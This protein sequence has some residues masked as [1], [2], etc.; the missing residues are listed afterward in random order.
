MKMQRLVLAAV[1]LLAG[2]GGGGAGSAMTPSTPV[3]LQSPPAPATNAQFSIAIPAASVSSAARVRPQYMS[4][5]TRSVTI[6]VKG[7]AN[8]GTFDVSSG[9]K[10]CTG[11]SD[12]SRTCMLAV[13][14][15]SGND[16]F[17]VT[18]YDQPGGGGNALASGSIEQSIS[19]SQSTI[20]VSLTGIT[21]AIRLALQNGLPASG[22]PA[23]IP[24]IVQAIDADGNTI[25]GT[26]DR[27]I[28][29]A[30]NDS[31]RHTHLSATSIT[32]SDTAVTLSY[33]GGT[34]TGDAGITASAPGVQAPPP[35]TLHA[36]PSIVAQYDLP[37]ILSQDG[38]YRT[39]VGTSGIVQGS[40]GNLWIAGAT[41]G[42][43]LKM[44]P[45]GSITT[46]WPPTP[47]AF[48]QEEVLGKDGAV[49]FTERDGN[50]IGR[51]TTSGAITEY[52]IPT[53]Y[54]NP[55]GIA[56]GPDGN[57]WFV[58]QSGNAV[59]KVN[60]DGSI[61]EYPLPQGAVPVDLTAGPDGNLWIDE[62]GWNQPAAIAVMKTDG[63]LLTTHPL[64]KNNPMPYGIITGPDGNLWFGEYS[65]GAI[66]RM[67]PSGQVTE[68]APPSSIPGVVSLA[69][70]KDGNIWFAESGAGVA[71]TGQLGYIT[72]GSS[73]IHE[74][75]LNMPLH[76]RN[77]TFDSS[78]ALW[79]SGFY[80]DD[81]NVG[82]VIP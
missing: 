29:L 25:L 27:T 26:Y 74:V 57:I 36:M 39:A 82:E 58:E 31:S 60:A 69:V 15:P 21:S 22:K 77:I 2:C 65:G 55:L 66:A 73:T 71:A 13:Q 70:S 68:Y 5:A 78:G 48:P 46:Y 30:D 41:A 6:A 10:L 28:T 62:T 50:N 76:V 64:A 61:T 53:Q 42:A 45:D 38:T 35:V 47:Y 18:A 32:A 12:G 23:S 49:W 14:A 4:A 24:V 51:I 81:S 1:A 16:T 3:P 19:A 17:K 80:Y 37:Y 43:I 59:G 52:P 79:Y 7:G 8:L 63:T 20:K 54:A 33:D 67:T 9:S 56:V 75:Y 11:A 34:M 72:P 40:D 44:K